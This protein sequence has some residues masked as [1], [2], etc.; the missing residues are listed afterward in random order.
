M[1]P[2]A[3]PVNSQLRTQLH[4]ENRAIYLPAISEAFTD[5]V[6]NKAF[7]FPTSFG[8]AE[9][10]FLD[11]ASPIFHYPYALYSVGNHNTKVAPTPD[12]VSQRDRA[13]TIVLGDSGGYQIS[14]NKKQGY[15]Q[16]RMVVDNMRWMESIADH[17][18]VLDFPTGGIDGG[19]MAA[20]AARLK[21]AGHD[22]DAINAG[23]RLGLDY[24]A[25]LLQTRLNND[26]F[27]AH[28]APGATRFLNVLQGR[29]ERESKVWYD[30]V[31]HYPFEGWAF[32][33]HHQNRFSL[34]LARLID[35]RDD[36]LLQKA[37]WI[38]VLGV[39]VLPI[40]VMITQV[41]RT[42]RELYNPTIQFSFDTATPFS[43]A[44]A[45]QQL[46]AGST[47]D[48]AGWSFQMESQSYWDRADEG[49]NIGDLLEEYLESKSARRRVAAR[50][51]VSKSVALGDI[52]DPATGKVTTPGRNLLV[53]HNVEALV[54][55][56]NIAHD[57]YYDDPIIRDPKLT[58]ISLQTLAVFIDKILRMP[59]QEAYD[60]IRQNKHHLDILRT[61]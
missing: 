8:P 50:T 38:H 19:M 60:T 31:K 48:E 40:G 11:P 1:P 33:G 29:S 15:F 27:V 22:L 41:Q 39:G 37:D 51:A 54:D 55:A 44:G 5:F 45:L 21:A 28:R 23:N 3:N 26:D 34:M 32:A 9:M 47:F 57:T 7:P 36:E 53:H 46:F 42:I 61:V 13:S 4:A 24:N 52:R 20:H 12:M 6:A 10:N 14:T 18:M 58:P 2:A 16:Q 49:R 59:T 43:S 25:C 35:M 30:S 56:H 17:S